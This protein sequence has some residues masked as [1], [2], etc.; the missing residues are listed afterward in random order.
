MSIQDLKSKFPD[1]GKDIKINL[2]N[3]LSEDG[4]KDLTKTQIAGV[5]LSSAYATKNKDVV[6]AIK[7]EFADELSDAV[8][9]GAKEAASVMAMNNI[10]Y[11]FVH[12][13]SDPEYGSMP[14]NLR[15]QIIGK[16]PVEK[17]DFELNSIA[18]SAIN[19]C[20]MCMD[21]HAN[22]LVKAGATKVGIQSA[23]RIASVINAA[24]QVLAID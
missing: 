2:G 10:Y 21:S 15:M 4:A 18:V 3:V 11:R 13:T 24:A 19:G 1:F 16:P 9:A 7:S 23:I 8:L 5:A 22:I 6:D 12:L 17:L 20:G 14:A